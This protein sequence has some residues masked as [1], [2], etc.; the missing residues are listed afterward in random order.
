[1]PLRTGACGPAT[2][3]IEAEAV[4]RLLERVELVIPGIYNRWRSVPARQV[5]L[6]AFTT[7]A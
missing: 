1:L 7:Y 5:F 2:N 3:R 6:N 4:K